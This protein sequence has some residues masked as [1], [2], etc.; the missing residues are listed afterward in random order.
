[1]SILD[2]FLNHQFKIIATSPRGQWVNS[3]RPSDACVGKLAI[4][5]SDNGLSP[6]RCQ[7]II[8]TSAGILVIG[9][10]GTNFS[11][12]L[13]EIQTFSLKKIRLKMS[14][15]KCCSFRLGLNALPIDIQ[16]PYQWLEYMYTEVSREIVLLFGL[17]CLVVNDRLTAWLIPWVSDWTINLSSDLSISCLLTWSIDC[18]LV[19][20]LVWTKDL[21]L[22]PSSL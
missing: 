17:Y 4:I 2:I 21:S 19:Q 3:L 9:P 10:L 5:G 12:I 20:G 14:S 22:V 7:A 11:E 8:W 6:E 1:M 18:L 15:A 13:I 16:I